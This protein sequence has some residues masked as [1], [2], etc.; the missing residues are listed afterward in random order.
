MEDKGQAPL[1][2]RDEWKTKLLILLGGLILLGM[3]SLIWAESVNRH[4]ASTYGIADPSSAALR[5]ENRTSDFAVT[6]V[7]L[8]NTEGFVTI[9]DVGHEISMGEEAVVE[10][11]PGAY[12]VMVFYGE[13]TQTVAGR[14]KGSLSA[15]FTVS[16]EKAVILCLQGGRSSPEGLIFLPPEL[17]FK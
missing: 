10:I 9:R 6:R 12:L 3:G 16:P 7:T 13:T 5:I 17:V 11:A 4:Q 1:R 2:R 8:Q 14:P 15:S